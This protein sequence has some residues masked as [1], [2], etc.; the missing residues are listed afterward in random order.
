MSVV[1]AQL[2]NTMNTNVIPSYLDDTHVR[3]ITYDISYN[4]FVAQFYQTNKFS[5]LRSTICLTDTSNSV[6]PL[7]EDGIIDIS[8]NFDVS[9]NDTLTNFVLNAYLADLSLN[10]VN[11][12]S[13]C[14]V[15][16]IYK[17]TLL[18]NCLPV[19]NNCCCLSL[20]RS[21]FDELY[22]LGN[23]VF[24]IVLVISDKSYSSDTTI[25]NSVTK[26]VSE[27]NAE[28]Q[29]VTTIYNCDPPL[30]TQPIEIRLTFNIIE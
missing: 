28:G 2:C 1:L 22:D 18:W 19:Y 25:I 13:A 4:E 21:E 30:Q 10:S 8:G 15:I 26:T 3:D 17:D 23:T 29:T 12:L 11:E 14:S 5:T 20:T 24:T 9:G 16:N 27:I 7:T 6:V